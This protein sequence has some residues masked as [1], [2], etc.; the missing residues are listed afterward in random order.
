MFLFENA[1]GTKFTQA[2]FLQ[3]LEALA[4]VVCGFIGLLLVGFAKGMPHR[5]FAVSGASQVCAKAITSLSLASGLS[6]PVA[7]LAKSCK[8]VPVMVGS[9][10]L[11]KAR[12]SLREYLQVGVIVAGTAI[13]GMGGKSG[14]DSSVLGVAFIVGS[15]ICDGVT[16]GV[17]A[18][19]KEAA[20]IVGAT[21]S[22]ADFMFWTN[23]YMAI[24]AVVVAAGNDEINSG[25]GYLVANSE[26]LEKVVWF[27]ICS[28]VGQS[29][30]FFTISHFDPLVCSTVTTTRKIF[31]VLLSIFFK[32]HTLDAS[33]LF[34]VSLA[35]L[36]IV[37]EMQ[38]KVKPKENIKS[39]KREDEESDSAGLLEKGKGGRRKR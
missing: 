32:G 22:A 28:V 17:Q 7:T 6:F 10:L 33:G 34:G 31:S 35:C 27:C 29:F 16:G 21:P 19:L 26:I 30:I 20:K 4:N 18:R 3:M 13:V 12:Y 5:M 2:W 37:L 23:L 25:A 15:L 24:V 14:G 38:S 11:G 8:M 39:G 1:G 9:L 36:G